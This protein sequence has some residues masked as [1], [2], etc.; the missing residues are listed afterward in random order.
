[1]L[2]SLRPPPRYRPLRVVRG[3]AV[4]ATTAWAFVDNVNDHEWVLVWCFGG[5]T[6]GL[7][8]QII[9]LFGFAEP[10]VIRDAGPNAQKLGGD[11]IV[12]ARSSPIGKGG[13]VRNRLEPRQVRL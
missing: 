11:R 1:M 5:M 8:V 6:L 2:A 4:S 10:T 3:G 12:S 7:I 13:N 9:G